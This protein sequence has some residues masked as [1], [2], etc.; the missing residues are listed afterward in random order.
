MLSEETIQLLTAHVDGEL[1]TRQRQAVLRLLQQS[2]EARQIVLQLQENAH[3]IDQLPRRA[4]DRSFAADVLRAIAQC[5]VS[6]ERSAGARLR[7]LPYAA[8]A[9]AAC[10]LF[11][12]TLAGILYLTL[13][14]A[15]QQQP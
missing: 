9:L 3:K 8:A 6:A 15:G 11:F 4:L 1:D 2:S 12:M 14:G 10:V 7:W 5:A 13:G